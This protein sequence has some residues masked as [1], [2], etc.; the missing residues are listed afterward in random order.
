[1]SLLLAASNFQ[2]RVEQPRETSSPSDAVHPYPAT[3]HHRS[4]DGNTAAKRRSVEAATV[5]SAA[6]SIR[7]T[8]TNYPIGIRRVEG[9]GSGELIARGDDQHQSAHSSLTRCGLS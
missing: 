8:G 6:T 3:C 9:V 2:S 1:M 5:A 7:A 4:T